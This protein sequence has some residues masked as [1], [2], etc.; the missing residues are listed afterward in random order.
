MYRE[1]VVINLWIGLDW[2]SPT[3]SRLYELHRVINSVCCHSVESIGVAP[4][5]TVY[6]LYRVI[7]YISFYSPRSNRC[8][9]LDTHQAQYFGVW[10]LHGLRHRPVQDIQSSIHIWTV[11]K[12]SWVEVYAVSD[13]RRGPVHDPRQTIWHRNSMY[14]GDGFPQ[15]IRQEC[16]VYS[17]TALFKQTSGWCSPLWI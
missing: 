13:M 8:S 7:H 6:R 15:H 16:N 2:R 3:F 10:P 1:L 9:T 17:S 12:F 14:N 5:S 4:P 11:S